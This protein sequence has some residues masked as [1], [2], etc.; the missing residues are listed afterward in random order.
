M[1][2]ARWRTP[3]V[4]PPTPHRDPNGP[5]PQAGRFF[6]GYLYLCTFQRAAGQRGRA[7]R[8]ESRRQGK[9]ESAGADGDQPAR[10]RHRFPRRNALVYIPALTRL[11]VNGP[12][13]PGRNASGARSASSATAP[14]AS[15]D[16]HVPTRRRPRRADSRSSAS[17]PVTRHSRAGHA[18]RP[19]PAAPAAPR[20]R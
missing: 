8:P 1:L 3:H 19:R 15:P 20:Q 5:L 12:S 14:S 10:S 11:R 17:S 18:A 6:F 4:V 16:D 7:S 9:R 2:A 13:S